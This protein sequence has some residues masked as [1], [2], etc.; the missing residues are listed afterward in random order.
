A[1]LLHPLP[2]SP[3]REVDLA[4]VPTAAPQRP[5]DLA[6][7]LFME[8]TVHPREG[9]LEQYVEKA[10]SHYAEEMRQNAA[11]GRTLLRIEASFR[12]AF[13]SHQRREVILW[14]RV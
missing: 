7:T 3:L 10:G 8:D 6:L 14:Q 5:A 9:L 11:E 2:W 12:S 13:G 4:Q 1:K